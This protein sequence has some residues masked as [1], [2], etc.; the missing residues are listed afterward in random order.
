MSK[1]INKFKKLYPGYAIAHPELR[2]CMLPN[3]ARAFEQ[4]VEKHCDKNPDF[5]QYFLHSLANPDTHYVGYNKNQDIKVQPVMRMVRNM[6]IL[7]AQLDYNTEKWEAV[8]ESVKIEYQ[9][10]LENEPLL[11]I[12]QHVVM[13]H[14]FMYHNL[15]DELCKEHEV[16]VQHNADYRKIYQ[17]Q[18]FAQWVLPLYDPKDGTAGIIPPDPFSNLEAY[19]YLT[20]H[21]FTGDAEFINNTQDMTQNPQYVNAIKKSYSMENIMAMVANMEMAEIM[22][23]SPQEGMSG[24][25]IDASGNISDFPDQYKF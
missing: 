21:I 9:H 13:C 2:A 10:Q 15:S 3:E 8:P 19:Q 18:L 14:N 1:F 7:H 20:E 11:Q 25:N 4:Q 12:T 5:K 22:L 16:L 23:E 24:S 6:G 17:R